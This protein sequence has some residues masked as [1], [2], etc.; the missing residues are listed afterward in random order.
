MI[1]KK[2]LPS[3][4]ILLLFAVFAIV[5]LLRQTKAEQA[6]N[7]HKDVVIG[8]IHKTNSNRSFN[9]VYY[10]YYFNNQK[11]ES[12]EDIDNHTRKHVRSLNGR[13][14]KVHLSSKNP[15]HSR[16]QLN[17]EVSDTLAIKS[18]GFKME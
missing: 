1:K 10:T 6:I 11:F 9:L 15:E 17:E 4:I 14:F 2:Y 8:K 13:F 18:A 16:I 5:S 3:I 7:D 12:S